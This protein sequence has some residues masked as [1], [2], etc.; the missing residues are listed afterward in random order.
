MKTLFSRMSFAIVLLFF[1]T[2]L[3]I[4]CIDFE[5]KF[6]LVEKNTESD[7]SDLDEEPNFDK[8]SSSNHFT[9]STL[10]ETHLARKKFLKLKTLGNCISISKTPHY[11]P[12][13]MY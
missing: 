4:S 13:D 7:E 10:S 5:T 12:P 2:E 8:I 6:E 9:T 3:S 1:V 11:S